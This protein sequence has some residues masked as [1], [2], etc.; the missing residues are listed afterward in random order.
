MTIFLS[1]N[2]RCRFLRRGGWPG[3]ASIFVTD[4]LIPHEEPLELP[5]GFSI[6]SPNISVY[7]HAGPCGK[8]PHGPVKGKREQHHY[9]YL[10][11]AKGRCSQESSKPSARLKQLSRWKM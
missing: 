10:R 3:L 7:C 6:L 9:V 5:K 4:F 8:L 2:K 1:R 11:A